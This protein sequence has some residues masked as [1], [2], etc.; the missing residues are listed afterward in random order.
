MFVIKEGSP[1]NEVMP[2][3]RTVLDMAVLL[4]WMTVG[5][6]SVQTGERESIEGEAGCFSMLEPPFIP[7]RIPYKPPD[8]VPSM[9][10]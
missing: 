9:M 2:V 10:R 4:R 3:R 8:K 7:L 5:Y 1:T 6:L